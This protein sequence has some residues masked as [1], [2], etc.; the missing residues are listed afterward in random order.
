[1]HGTPEAPAAAAPGE[2]STA[3]H[4]AQQA[5]RAEE[6][7]DIAH[8]WGMVAPKYGSTESPSFSEPTT[9]AVQDMA[10][11]SSS[12]SSQNSDSNKRRQQVLLRLISQASDIRS[13]GNELFKTRQYPQAE[14]QY[15][16]AIHTLQKASMYHTTAAVPMQIQIR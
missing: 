1:M 9:A 5:E 16:K 8:S 13:Q 3:V 12:S 10:S 6:G 15:S 4:A 14:I 2:S 11:F 7:R